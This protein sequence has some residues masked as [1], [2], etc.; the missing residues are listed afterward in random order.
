MA[1]RPRPD[2]LS[3]PPPTTYEVGYAR[4]PAA[5]RFRKGQSG[6]PQGRPRGARNRRPALNEEGLKDIV[7][8]EAYRTIKVNDGDRQVTVPIMQ[9]VVRSLALNAARG[10][11]RAQELFTELVHRTEASHKA[12]HDEWLQTAIDYKHEW[13]RELVRRQRLGITAPDPVPHPEA[14]S[15]EIRLVR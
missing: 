8:A 15:E 12:L 1:R 2:Q 13:E 3:R 10:Q 9:A 6:N 5:S 4:P 7:M 11:H 14:L